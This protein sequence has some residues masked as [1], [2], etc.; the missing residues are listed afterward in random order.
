MNPE[1]QG[2]QP[3]GFLLAIETMGATLTSPRVT[4]GVWTRRVGVVLA[5]LFLWRVCY[6]AI[7]PLDL[8]PDEAYYWD[9]SRQLDWGYYSKPPMIAWIIALATRLGGNSEFV[10]RLPA[11]CLGTLGLWPVYQLGRR[12]FDARVGFWSVLAVAATPG[13]AAMN[14]LMTIDAPFLC[15]WAFAVWCVWEL[16]TAD[17]PNPRWLPAAIVA[18]GL[19]LLSKQTMIA[20]MPLTLLW[21]AT[22]PSDRRKLHLPAVWLWIAGSLLFLTPV[23]WWNQQHGWIT[24]QHTREHFQS[25]AVGIS[26]HAVWLF[27][28]WG[29]QFGVVSPISCALM[30]G[31]TVAGLWSFRT[32]DRRVRFLL[33]LSAVPMLGVSGLSALQRVQPNWPAAFHLTAF[34]LMAAWGCGAWPIGASA[35]RFRRWLPA[36]VA[37]GAGLAAMVYVVPFAV[38]AS[39]LAGGP[40]D[41]TAR[42]RGWKTLGTKVGEALGTMSSTSPPLVIAAT[43]RGPVSALAYYLPGQP[44]VY[45]WNRTG[46]IESQHEVWGGIEGHSGADALLVTH[47][48]VELPSELARAFNHVERGSEVVCRLGPSRTQSLQLW[49]G[50]GF[51]G[52]PEPI[53]SQPLV[54]PPETPRPADTPLVATQLKDGVQ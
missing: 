22:S 10:I 38:P 54:D 16:F 48:G 4:D 12:L 44:R 47:G 14:L 31:L 9:W 27:E 35:P 23:V 51:R 28:F 40:L 15:A 8:C 30:I 43:G 33:C 7:F 3:L 32:T 1:A 37:T 19:G 29:S 20:L 5:A 49:H 39:P 18:T 36:G 13:M 50:R 6:L 53:G 45:R 11:A 34:M 21:L 25:R 42:L 2:L 24:A 17:R 26:Q 52:W 46:V 41:A